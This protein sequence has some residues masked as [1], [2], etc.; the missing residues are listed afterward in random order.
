MS[1]RIE[2]VARSF[3]KLITRSITTGH[4]P[5][6]GNSGTRRHPSTR[7]R[8]GVRCPAG[9]RRIGAGCIP[10]ALIGALVS[11]VAHAQSSPTVTRA[12]LI[13]NGTA[14]GA[15][16]G[17]VDCNENGFDD[18]DDIADMTSPDCNG[19]AI[20]DECEINEN[21]TA[22]GGP[23]FCNSDCD[24]DCNHSGIPD[25]CELSGNDCNS[26]GRPDECGV[27]ISCDG[28]SILEKQKL[29]ASDASEDDIFGL[30]VSISGNAV[31]VGARNVDCP[32]GE[33]CGA[34]YVF[35]FDGN[36]WIEQQKLTASDGMAVDWFGASVSISGE[37]AVVGAYFD[38][39]AS[40]P[41][42]GAAYVYRFDG[43]QWV[44]EQKLTASNATFSD[45]F[46][47]SVFVGADTIM[48]G[49]P[50]YDCASGIACG[51]VYVFRYDGTNWVEVQQL[52][53]S[54]TEESRE[55]GWSV[56]FDGGTAIVGDRY[57]DCANGVQCG[58]AHVFRFDGTD[59]IEEQKLTASDLVQA[60]NFGSSVSISG[61]TAVVG[62][63]QR[64]CVGAG[65]WCGAAY[66]YRFD[67]TSWI[68]QQKLTSPD[69]QSRDHFGDS[70]AVSGETIVASAQFENCPAGLDCGAAYV[71]R[72]DGASWTLRQR[73]TASDASALDTMGSSVSLSG[74]TVIAGAIGVGCPAGTR[75]GSA[76]VFNLA[77]A[78]CNCDGVANRC[79][80][81]QADGDGDFVPD[82]CDV[83][84]G[85]DD[86][87]DDDHDGIPNDCD[88]CPNGSNTDDSDGDG[89]VDGCDVCPGAD[90]TID[91]DD[92]GVPDGC[93]TCPGADDT[94]DGDGDGVPDGCDICPGGDDAL[95]GD[96]DAIPDDCDICPGSDDGVDTDGDGV[97]DG[98]DICPGAD[99]TLDGDGDGVPDDCDICLTGDDALDSDGDGVP[100]GC[101]LCEGADD[102]VDS[103]N[104]GVPDGCDV[105][106]GIDDGS[107]DS[108]G[109]GVPDVCDVCP[110]G[111][112]TLDVD[113]DGVPFD[114]DICLGGDDT[115]DG[116]GD[117]I[118]DDC[119]ACPNGSNTDDTDGDGVVDGCDICPGEDDSVDSDG[120]G[121]PD[122]CDDCPLDNPDDTDGDSVC[123][124][125]DV[126]PGGDDTIDGDGDGVPDDCDPCD[127][128]VPGDCDLVSPILA[129]APHDILKNRYISID[130]R[131]EDALNVGGLPFDI[132]VTLSSTLVN[133][134]TAVGESW[135]ANAPD[136]ACISVV[137]PTQPASPPDW[138]AC[139]TLHLTGCPIIPTSTYEIVGVSD[140]FSSEPPLVA[141]T[142]AKPGVK[143]HGDIVGFFNGIEWTAPN[144]VTSI[145]DAVAIIKAF[146]DINAFNA[147]HATRADLHPNMNGTQ[148]N[149]IVNFNDVLVDLFGFQGFEYPGPQI[150]LCQN[151]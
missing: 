45:D 84:P 70:V 145:D 143:W 60:D 41:Q 47:R 92:D 98:C 24:P 16:R 10:A 101:D 144:G 77:D 63:S 44:E 2:R 3:A 88:V 122:G 64:H 82:A 103:D 119:D 21:S 99:D 133:G 115:I 93:D 37:T 36:K 104:D 49:T 27:F 134:V 43:T 109:D 140:G 48:V 113:G 15:S 51:A 121:V 139:P 137:G 97:P 89:V 127:N 75:C 126:C 132:R 135:W 72:F 90:D 81:S 6:R 69:I 78:D 67:G 66:V 95:D 124:S 71:Y 123:D 94:L 120:D 107:F 26:D 74:D 62:A 20:P 39:C 34:A 73:L 8:E 59:W 106:P 96:D 50:D 147:P 138:S 150:D 14:P 58:A 80:N 40:G 5:S 52:I 100:D 111:D 29:T 30:S 151:P 18:A 149:R 110:G 17:V 46:G 68:E 79:D 11:S 114:C 148:I 1:Y 129:A 57:A 53:A 83:C 22:P 125:S 12:S 35:R 56:S 32:D 102:G 85:G 31:I 108:D 136:S 13:D 55:F 7:Y 54:D 130:P 131:G 38:D 33:D 146:Q 112:D 25:E 142:Q 105:C 23:F 117:G 19:N 128:N 118:P 141:D 76:Y 86:S 87:L 91:T 28:A 116:D 9:S 61:D 42:C 4:G 65:F